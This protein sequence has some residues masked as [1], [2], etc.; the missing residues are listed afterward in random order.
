M[1]K[2]VF[3]YGSLVSTKDVARTLGREPVLIHPVELKGWVRDWGVVID[4]TIAAH[5]CVRLPDGSVA[6]GYIA[7]LNVRRPLPGER[8]THPNGVLFEVTDDEL[9]KLDDREKCYERLDVTAYVV[10][11]PTGTVYVYSGL[12]KHLIANHD[13]PDGSAVVIPGAYAELVK[14]GFAE[15]SPDMHQAYLK[16]TLSSRLSVVNQPLSL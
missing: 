13:G 8:P 11:A 10:N 1:A 7:V 14:R 5:R 6:P 16:S 15:L 3:G 4:N 12:D 2:Y 9:K